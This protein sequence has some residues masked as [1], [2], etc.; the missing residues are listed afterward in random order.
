[1]NNL[2]NRKRLNALFMEKIS[3]MDGLHGDVRFLHFHPMQAFFKK[4]EA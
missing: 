2:E 1:M 4:V 3:Q